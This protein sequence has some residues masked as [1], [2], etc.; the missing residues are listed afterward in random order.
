MRM[1]KNTWRPDT[2]GCVLEF[3]FDADEPE[4]TRVH[5]PTKVV[6]ACQHHPDGAG[7]EAHHAAVLAENQLKNRA[8]NEVL[9]QIP[10]ELKKDVSWSLDAER[11]VIISVPESEK[12]KVQLTEAGALLA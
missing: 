7:P 6:K 12:G 11:K 1:T 5:T 9:A 10:D 8:L 3:E 2:C 4:E